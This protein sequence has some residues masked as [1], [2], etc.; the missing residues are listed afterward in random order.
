MLIRTANTRNKVI[1]DS[2]G[3]AVQFRT[4]NPKLLPMA[5]QSVSVRQSSSLPVTGGLAPG[6]AAPTI[7]A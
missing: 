5:F 7:S 1:T 3:R 6:V 2:G 4:F